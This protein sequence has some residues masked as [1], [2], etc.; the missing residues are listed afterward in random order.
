[1]GCRHAGRRESPRGRARPGR[2]ES[3]VKHARRE[4]VSCNVPTGPNPW[5]LSLRLLRGSWLT[6][7]LLAE[8]TRSRRRRTRCSGCRT[9]C[10][11]ESAGLIK[12]AP[13]DSGK[14]RARSRTRRKGAQMRAAVRSASNEFTWEISQNGQKPLGQSV[15]DLWTCRAGCCFF[16]RRRSCRVTM[17]QK[18]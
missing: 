6:E 18:P 2:R 12:T 1:M 16:V 4:Q 11:S 14:Y 9:C 17:D 3:P 15:M 13:L 5:G 10:Q 8:Q 7:P